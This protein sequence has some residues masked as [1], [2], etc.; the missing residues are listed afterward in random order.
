MILASISS[1]VIRPNTECGENGSPADLSGSI[2]PSLEDFFAFPKACSS[3]R[4]RSSLFC[5][6][7]NSISG[8]NVRVDVITDLLPKNGVRE[9]GA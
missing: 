4:L 9:P 1:G 3:N 2:R 7:S 5:T 6:N 8:R